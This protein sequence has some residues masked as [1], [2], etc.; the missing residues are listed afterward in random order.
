MV[1]SDKIMELE[2]KLKITTDVI[3]DLR[4][5]IHCQVKLE[6]FTPFTTILTQ[7]INEAISSMK[8]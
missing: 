6:G 7:T 5:T 3:E 1:Q 8:E 4:V 2:K